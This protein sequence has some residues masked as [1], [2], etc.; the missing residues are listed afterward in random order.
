MNEAT[1]PT[2]L[3]AETQNIA[4]TPP[5]ETLSYDWP[6]PDRQ[7]NQSQKP[8]P[9]ELRKFVRSLSILGVP[10]REI[11]RRL[12]QRLNLRNYSLKYMYRDFHADLLAQNRAGRRGLKT[13]LI[14]KPPGWK[15]IATGSKFSYAD[16]LAIIQSDLDSRD[17][18][19]LYGAKETVIY[20]MRRGDHPFVQ[21]LL[22]RLLLT[23]DK[24]TP[25]AMA[26]RSRA[27]ATMTVRMVQQLVNSVDYVWNL[28]EKEAL[29]DPIGEIRAAR[30]RPN[31]TTLYRRNTETGEI[32]SMECSH[33]MTVRAA[34]KAG[35]TEEKPE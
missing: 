27:L 29:I 22:P 25:D 14:E 4:G 24:T 16:V 7:I 23:K 20:S 30:R 31:D 3:T 11:N 5:P 1:A 34:K 28:I 32:E 10:P 2:A 26:R 18:A 19:I 6:D 15:P 9:P 12:I 35:W 13:R 33:H 17:L 8:P 21:S